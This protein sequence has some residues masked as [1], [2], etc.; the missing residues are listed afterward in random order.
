[1]TGRVVV[2]GTPNGLA[3]SPIGVVARVGLDHRLGAAKEKKW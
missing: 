1:L 3:G 2:Q